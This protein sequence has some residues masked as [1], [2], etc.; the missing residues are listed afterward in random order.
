LIFWPFGVTLPPDSKMLR[1]RASAGGLSVAEAVGPVE[2]LA[3]AE[4]PAE[5]LPDGVAPGDLLPE[6]AALGELL[7]V[8]EPELVPADGAVE[9]SGA[10]VQAPSTRQSAEAAAAAAAVRCGRLRLPALSLGALVVVPLVLT[11]SLTPRSAVLGP[12]RTWDGCQR[13]GEAPH[14]TVTT[15]HGRRGVHR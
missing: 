4:P 8:P 9:V 7:A 2:L 15:S 11:C 6:G 10:L 14:A 13:A 5:L 12:H 3:D 1:R